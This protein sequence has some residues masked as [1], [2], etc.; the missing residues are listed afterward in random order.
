MQTHRDHLVG[1]SCV[2]GQGRPRSERSDDRNPEYSPSGTS[3]TSPVSPPL[4]VSDINSTLSV[5][6]GSVWGCPQS[7]PLPPPLRSPRQVTVRPFSPSPRWGLPQKLALLLLATTPSPPPHTELLCCQTVTGNSRTRCSLLC[8]FLPPR[9]GCH[10]CRHCRRCG[11][12]LG[13]GEASSWT[14]ATLPPAKWWKYKGL[15]LNFIWRQRS[16]RQVT[17]MDDKVIENVNEKVNHRRW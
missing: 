15:G 8:S 1:R 3:S 14:S 2:V 11:V 13:G 7:P 17:L 4:M 6:G 16:K 10:C 9:D 5:A 12:H